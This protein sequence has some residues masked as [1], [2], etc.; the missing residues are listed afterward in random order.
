M[1]YLLVLDLHEPL[2]C[3]QH[4]PEIDPPRR[5]GDRPH[6]LEMRVRREVSPSRFEPGEPNEILL[7]QASEMDDTN[8]RQER[9]R[10]PLDA[11]RAENP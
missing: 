10:D 11:V 7:P 4:P 3:P 6:E 9:C 2:E 1:P 8:P 5:P